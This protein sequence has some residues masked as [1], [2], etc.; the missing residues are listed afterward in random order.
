[1]MFTKNSSSYFSGGSDL[2]RYVNGTL[3]SVIGFDA[4]GSPIIKT[5]AG[6]EII[7]DP[8]E[9]QVEVDGKSRAAISQIPLR[10]AY[11]MTVH[12]SQGM[13]MDAAVIDLS[14]AFEYGQGYVAL[15]R[16]RR[17]TG[18]HLLGLNNRALMVHPL[19][20]E[21]DRELRSQ[22]LSVNAYFGD[23]GITEI[24][25]LQKNF[26]NAVGGVWP[27]GKRRPLKSGRRPSGSR[28]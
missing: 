23:L 24:A 26:V 14:R 8:V 18:L 25:S 10:L 21:T 7:T 28:T 15:S 16:V 3:G 9:W 20:L 4:A 5:K 11:A 1:V 2:G 22:S 12:K 27:N 13:S 17:L 6:E 19:I